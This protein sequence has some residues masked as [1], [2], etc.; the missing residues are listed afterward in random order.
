MTMRMRMRMWM[1]A[2]V[3]VRGG[4]R[5]LR[6]AGRTY[7]D[8]SQYPVFPWVL[9]NYT[10][11]T[12][13]LTNPD[14]YRDLHYPMGA[15]SPERRRRA[16]EQYSTSAEMYEAC[17]EGGDE[18][19]LMFQGPPWHFGSNYSNAGFVSWYLVRMEPFTSYHIFL[20]VRW[21]GA[22]VA[23]NQ[24]LLGSPLPLHRVAM[25]D[26][27]VYRCHASP[28]GSMPLPLPLPVAGW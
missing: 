22:R 17:V 25:H 8:L 21:F 2:C 20:Q 26:V 12:I 27:N 14:N 9:S 1:C 13:D 3:C 19:M 28:F 23:V 24:P 10:S 5:L 6:L 16:T 7:N 11:A 18:S 15:Q 4:P